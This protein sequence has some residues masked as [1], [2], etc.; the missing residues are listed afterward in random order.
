MNWFPI[1]AD[2]LKASGHGAI[3]DKAQTLATGSVDPVA[4]AIANIIAEV[5]AAVRT[6]NQLDTD[7]TKIPRSLKRLAVQ[8]ILFSLMERIGLPLNDDQKKEAQRHTDRLE[9][10]FQHKEVLEPADSP[11]TASGP[12]NPGTWNSAAKVIMRMHPVPAP[13]TQFQSDES[14]YAN[15]DAPADAP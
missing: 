5:R 6:G 12:V 3:I 4:D 13:T 10:L 14:G 1:T 2:D 8:M 7:A 15:L 11:D 9:Q